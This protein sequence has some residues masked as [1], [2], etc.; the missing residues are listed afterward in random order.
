[1]RNA[2]VAPEPS[3]A[4]VAWSV[5]ELP[6]PLPAGNAQPGRDLEHINFPADLEEV[7]LVSYD[8][9]RLSVRLRCPSASDYRKGFILGISCGWCFLFFIVRSSA[10]SGK[11][12][13]DVVAKDGVFWSPLPLKFGEHCLAPGPTW[14]IQCRTICW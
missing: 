1:M 12:E 6:P 5:D 4:A 11:R 3:P 13:A 10:C 2:R 8:F 7:D 14:T 9:V